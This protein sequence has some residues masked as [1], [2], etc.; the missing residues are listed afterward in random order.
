LITQPFYKPQD[1]I[2]NFKANF[3]NANSSNQETKDDQTKADLSFLQILPQ[4]DPEDKLHYQQLA[5]VKS[6]KAEFLS[7]GQMSAL[8][9]HAWKDTKVYFEA[10]NVN[11]PGSKHLFVADTIQKGNLF[12]QKWLCT[13]SKHIFSKHFHKGGRGVLWFS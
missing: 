5:M 1:N 11:D 13:I 2:T 10:T 8:A 6:G 12:F 3:I 7:Q 4:Q 9:I